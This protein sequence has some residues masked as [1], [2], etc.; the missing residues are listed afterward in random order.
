MSSELLKIDG[1]GDA[2]ITFAPNAHELRDQMLAK[3]EEI[4]V[5]AD[6][7][8][9]DVAAGALRGIT[10][11]TREIE[12]G[13]KATKTPVLALGKRIDEAAREF[14]E[15]L[16]REKNRLSRLLGGYESEQRKL[17]LEAKRKAEAEA[18]EAAKEAETTG[19][20]EAAAEKIAAAHAQ[21]TEAAHRPE[22]TTVRETWKFEVEDIDALFK[23]APHLCKIEPDGQAI[24][25]AIKKN[26]NI[27]GLRI[28]KEAK[29]YTK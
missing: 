20:M 10:D 4:D 29:S 19:D 7:L 13:R 18:A 26:Q 15:P 14:S 2:K 17:M 23:A 5:V 25:A 8:D 3:A 22:G 21:V 6:A 11:V 28:W 16:G 24:R 27:A 9:A 1:L 12:A